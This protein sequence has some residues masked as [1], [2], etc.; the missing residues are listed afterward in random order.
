MRGD[1]KIPNK[2]YLPPVQTDSI[3]RHGLRGHEDPA[4]V[5]SP[6]GVRYLL[7]LAEHHISATPETL[8]RIAEN[9]T[10]QTGFYSTEKEQAKR[11]KSRFLNAFEDRC[12]KMPAW[13]TGETNVKI[14]ILFMHPTLRTYFG[15]LPNL[16]KSCKPAWILSF[17]IL[18]NPIGAWI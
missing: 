10:N 7:K 4:N 3:L 14:Q 1:E 15:G 18:D 2:N 6:R 12:Q 8:I 16:L 11:I 13:A 5:L 17:L 9:E